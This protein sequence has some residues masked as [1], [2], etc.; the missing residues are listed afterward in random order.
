[1][2][3]YHW[4]T[5]RGWLLFAAMGF[6]WGIPYFLIRVAVKQLEPPVIV[7]FRTVLAASVLLVVANRAGATAFAFEHGLAASA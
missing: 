6:I 2:S 3:E 5:K 1:M 7:F 4:V